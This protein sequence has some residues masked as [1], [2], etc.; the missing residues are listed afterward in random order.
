MSIASPLKRRLRSTHRAW[1]FRRAWRQFIRRTDE[2]LAPGSTVLDDLVYGWGNESWS[3]ASE[4]L[5]ACIAHA[6]VA[7]QPI[8]ECGSGLSTLLLGWIAQRNGNAVWSLEHI[9]GWRLRVNSALARAGVQCATVCDSPLMDHGEYDWY[10]LPAQLPA[11]FGLVICDGPPAATRGG[12]FGMLPLMQSRLAADAVVLLDDAQRVE[13]QE[14]ARRWSALLDQEPQFLGIDK[15]YFR[16]GPSA[17]ARPA[18]TAG[19][20]SAPTGYGTPAPTLR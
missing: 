15:P 17:G 1:V 4:F 18:A 7:Q 14:I 10:S 12:R 11:R 2:A 16:F 20:A 13:E 6:R 8:L 5:R 9:P 19:S 3:G